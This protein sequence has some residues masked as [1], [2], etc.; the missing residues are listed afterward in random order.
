[1]SNRHFVKCRGFGCHWSGLLSPDCTADFT[2]GWAETGAIVVFQCPSCKQ[3]WRAR[4][5]GGKVK[6]L[7]MD[8]SENALDWLMWPPLEIGVGD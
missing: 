1:M 7:P 2:D 8:D 4:V 3:N 5:V 6:P